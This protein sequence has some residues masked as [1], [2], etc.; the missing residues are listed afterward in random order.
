M[1]KIM[2]KLVTYANFYCDLNI[3]NNPTLKRLIVIFERF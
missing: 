3:S 2:D 1:D